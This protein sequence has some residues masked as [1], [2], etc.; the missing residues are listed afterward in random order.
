MSKKII[1]DCER[2]RYPNTGLYHFCLQ[3]GKALN[4]QAGR[5]EE[6]GFYLPKAEKGIFGVDA[7]FVT[8]H[9]MQKY[10][11]PG[12]RKVDLW[13]C[14]YQN[15][16][17]FPFRKNVPVVLTVHDLNFLYD[18]RQKKEK[19]DRLLKH[20][21]DKINKASH[22]VAI[23]HYVLND[24]EK[25]LSLKGKATS[26]IYNG[27]NVNDDIPI[28][29][30]DFTYDKPF[31]FTIGTIAEKKNFHVL[32]SLLKGNDL[33]L[34]IG[35]IEQS[36]TYKQLIIEEAEKEGVSERLI[37]TGAISENDKKWLLSKCLA[38][39]FPSI[40]EGFGLPVIE[41][42]YYGKPI[43]LSGC[44]SL[45]EIGGD[46]AYYFDNFEPDHMRYVL[47][48]GLEEYKKNL[49][50][51]KIKTRGRSFSWETAAVQYFQVYRSLLAYLLIVLLRADI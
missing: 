35:G 2:M 51:E 41:A 16:N 47:K 30:P 11:F 1:F 37:F 29:D 19:T 20:L 8:H 23:S 17:Y 48:T 9:F 7:K 26:V 4:N 38:F 39:V 14:T 27:C 46:C 44:T 13:H 15:S 22:V 50:V 33:V 32:P 34:I 18:S 49:P 31:L 3:L 36:K 45:P 21:Q 25:H 5:E 6:I 42:M 24:L 10:I 43:F 12:T 40:A 28:L